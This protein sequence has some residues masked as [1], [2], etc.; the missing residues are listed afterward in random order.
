M[1]KFNNNVTN[2]YP[3]KRGNFIHRC[4]GVWTGQIPKRG[5]VVNGLRTTG[6]EGE[7]L[8]MGKHR[9]SHE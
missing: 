5:V 2:S 1:E 8:E 4:K 3:I 6:V 7:C 9:L